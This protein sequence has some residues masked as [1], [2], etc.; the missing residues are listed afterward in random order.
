MR[1]ACS[2]SD[3]VPIAVHN[4]CPQ[5][6]TISEKNEIDNELQVFIES[7]PVPEVVKKKLVE[8]RIEYKTENNVKIQR[9]LAK[10][11][12]R[13][14]RAFQRNKAQKNNQNGCDNTESS[15]RKEES[16]GSNRYNISD[17][18]REHDKHIKP[19][20]KKFLL[21]IKQIQKQTLSLKIINLSNYRLSKPELFVLRR[22]P[23]FTPTLKGN[24][25]NF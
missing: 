13:K 7:K 19:D 18:N 21:P 22:D 20:I 12:K 1:F 11:T 14:Q 4:L 2:Q 23:K 5:P 6:R 10:K 9:C 17:M 15:S 16:G 24:G 25:L 8:K 3:F